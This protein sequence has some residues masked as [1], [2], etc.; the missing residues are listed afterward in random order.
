M[1]RKILLIMNI[2]SPYRIQ[3]FNHMAERDDVEFKVLFLAENESNR[4][5]EVYKDEIK[6]NY[7]ILK[8]ICLFIQYYELPI[9]LNLGLLKELNKFKPDTICF[10]GYHYLATLEAL[11]YAKVKKIPITLWAGSH[12]LSGFIKNAFT[13]FYK[14]KIIPMFDSYV[15]YGSAAK[16]QLV[17]YGAQ[18]ENIIV[19]CNTVDIEWF[20][21]KCEKTTPE[22]IEEY[23]HRFPAKNILYVGNFIKHK[24][25]LELIKAF[26]NLNMRDVGLILVG[27]GVEK[28]NYVNYVGSNNISHIYFEGFKQKEKIVIY[29]E[30]ADI[31]VLP[32][33][34]EVWGLV[35][36]EAMSCGLPILSSIYAGAT[37]DIV[38]NGVNG[39]SFDP[40]N[41]HELA[42]KMKELLLDEDKRVMM[43][44]ES[45]KMISDKTPEKYAEDI[46][47]AT[48]RCV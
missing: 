7:V 41:I 22:Q 36:N 27:D 46:M 20:Q 39:Y 32:S 26:A 3:V 33:F 35:V 16:E 31:F 6:F 11:L 40:A 17:Y 44:K 12:M 28:E 25:V 13:A 21:R 29:Y 42:D 19:S 9:Y 23:R 1:K 38:R 24:G 18:P 43:G 5:W 8:N 14:K 48:L 15:T 37:R 30:F 4:R 10:C 2:I 45:L 47:K 34:N